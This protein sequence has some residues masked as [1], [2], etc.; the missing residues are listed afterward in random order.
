MS[1]TLYADLTAALDVQHEAATAAANVA[2][3][4]VIVPDDNRLSIRDADD[5]PGFYTEVAIVE[6]VDWTGVGDDDW[7]SPVARHV[8]AH[9]PART[10]RRL[11]AERR[12]LGRHSPCE[13]QVWP[14]GEPIP[15]PGAGD[16]L[17]TFCHGCSNIMDEDSV[18]AYDA[19]DQI[20]ASTSL[21]VYPCDEIRDLAA[22]LGVEVPA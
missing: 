1:D 18:A 5:G 22:R 17:P 3:D 10:L 16:P 11:E 6:Q 9:G 15:E 12:V 8:V 2:E 14:E 20:D 13:W 19:G 4:W 21:V 7:T